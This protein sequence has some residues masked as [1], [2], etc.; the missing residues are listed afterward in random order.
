MYNTYIYILYILH[1]KCLYIYT[2]VYMGIQRTELFPY[3]HFIIFYI[4]ILYIYIFNIFSYYKQQSFVSSNI[5]L[6]TL[7]YLCFLQPTVY[8]KCGATTAINSFGDCILNCLFFRTSK[9]TELISS[10]SHVNS[11][12]YFIIL[13]LLQIP[14]KAKI[15][16]YRN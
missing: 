9:D 11:N 7:K 5:F 10:L 6:R 8:L 2:Y 14:V 4:Y 1:M 13:L 16:K 12:I 15:E 3:F